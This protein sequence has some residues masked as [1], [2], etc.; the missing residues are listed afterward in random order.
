MARSRSPISVSLEPGVH[1][2]G[3]DR[4]DELAGV[5][6]LERGAEL[7]REST[8]LANQFLDLLQ[9]HTVHLRIDLIN[10][11]RQRCESRSPNPA[12]RGP[13][14]SDESRKLGGPITQVRRTYHTIMPTSPHRIMRF[15]EQCMGAGP[16]RL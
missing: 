9:V 15:V 4:A 11:W 1:P 13:I 6:E 7:I 3:F 12:Q 16:G 10:P 5:L 2:S 8:D 14:S